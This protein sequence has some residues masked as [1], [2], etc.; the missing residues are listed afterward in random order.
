MNI[1]DSSANIDFK[2]WKCED[3]LHNK[4]IESLSSKQSNSIFY[5]Y[6]SKTSKKRKLSS[7]LTDLS[8]KEDNSDSDTNSSSHDSDDSDSDESQ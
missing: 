3:I 2:K 7:C 8:D 5:N 6:S 4:N 1:I